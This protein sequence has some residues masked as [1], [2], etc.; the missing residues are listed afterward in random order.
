MSPLEHGPLPATTPGAPDAGPREAA[1]S[2]DATARPPVRAGRG[3]R[4]HAAAAAIILGVLAVFF[5]PA[6]VTGDQ[7]LFRDNG[8]MHW[9]MKRFVAEQLRQGHLAQWNP[10]GGLGVPLVAG[11]IDAVQ[12]PFNLLLVALPFELGF[13]AWV[14][15][16]FVLAATGAYAWARLLGRS[17]HAGLAA[18]LGFALSGALV[19]ASDNLTYLTTLAAL[20]WVFAA[21]HA[22]LERGGAR[23]VAALGIA[24]GLCAAGGDPQ[25]W[26]FAI[27]L[28]PVYA[29]VMVERTGRWWTLLLRGLGAAA[30]ALVGAAPFVLPVV[31]WIS[32]SSRGTGLDPAHL[33]RWN[34]PLSRLL[35]LVVPHLF[36]DTPGTLS[37][38]VYVAFGGG[39]QSQIPWM[40]SVYVG[41]SVLATALV[42]APRW[43]QVRWLLSCA[44]V[45]TW[46]ALGDAAGFGRLLP[47]LP[48]LGGFRYWEK[49]AIWPS[50]LVPLAAAYGFDDVISR[51]LRSARPA[52]WLAAGG[53]LVLAVAATGRAFP[54]GLVRLLPHAPEQALAAR[55]LAGNLVDG[56]L[57]S[58]TVCLL[59]GLAVAAIQRGLVRRSP[60]PV[61]ALVLV[62]D[63][64]AA[65]IRGYLL[66]DPVIV[67][68][69]PPFG[70]YLKARDGV[71]RV[72]TPYELTGN[73]WPALRQFESG[74]VWAG[75][76][77][78]ASFNVDQRVGNFTPY[79]GMLPSRIDRFNRRLPAD[80]HLPQIGLFGVGYLS[81]PASPEK[82][83][84]AGLSPPYD[85]VAVDP[86][87]PAYLLRVPHRERAYVAAE[88]TSVD[89]RAAMEFVLAADP[90]RT[91][92]SVV[93][94]P[95]PEGYLPPRG[96]ARIVEDAPERVVVEAT[97][98]GRGLLVLNDMYASGWSARVD[99]APVEILPANYL[100]RG[101]WVDGGRHIVEF[102]YRTPML[103]EGW[104]L[105]LAGGA[106]AATVALRS[107]RR[108]R[109]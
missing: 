63:L 104:L 86:L 48:V 24:S 73:R 37:S 42:A 57:E 108:R 49:M 97:T 95:V 91:E 88:L 45:F 39:E 34:L 87:L 62:G 30:I 61:L 76:M 71:Q 2:G 27:A 52:A 9:P 101:V 41:V 60:G 92:A 44:V 46:M 5:A 38:P 96:T 21:A 50:L 89:R 81:V 66:S 15:L 40:L 1:G 100:A 43:R 74:W 22:F 13:K 29:L 16:S 33:Q 17:L 18:G 98:D 105:F 11:A 94:A 106:V 99:G 93:E 7:F 47:H 51:R 56:L 78:D 8:R 35:E 53:G 36:R 75:H 83:R 67:P 72:F 59:F 19:G 25:A 31:A 109:P 6:L 79:T 55:T 32:E 26:G 58:G 4:A 90:R 65:N 3:W 68:R 69:A 84:A 12:H 77:L 80:R 23:R 103:R 20:P 54:E 85:V 10:Y 14:L 70:A 107:R 64:F 28:L 82:A 102:T